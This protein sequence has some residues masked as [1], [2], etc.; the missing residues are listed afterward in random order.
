MRCSGGAAAAAPN[1]T[2][3]T[4]ASGGPA[5][6]HHK[7][8]GSAVWQ[9]ALPEASVTW[10]PSDP[11]LAPSWPDSLRPASQCTVVSTGKKRQLQGRSWTVHAVGQK[12][13]CHLKP[14]PGRLP[15]ERKRTHHPW[16][17]V[18]VRQYTSEQV[19]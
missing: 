7:V 11:L 6:H 4:S 13:E 8:V 9:Q 12:P 15:A 14:L 18:C 16:L 10:H 1:G 3:F 5:T 2:A 19:K 17:A